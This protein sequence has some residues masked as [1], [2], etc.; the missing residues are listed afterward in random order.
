MANTAIDVTGI[1]EA[2]SSWPLEEVSKFK[3]E[4]NSAADGI[5]FVSILGQ[6]LAKDRL[7]PRQT[8]NRSNARPNRHRRKQLNAP[9]P[10]Y[11]DR[12]MEGARTASYS[13]TP[14]DRD[15]TD[16]PRLRHVF[17]RETCK[18]ACQSTGFRALVSR[19]L[20]VGPRPKS[21]I[22]TPRQE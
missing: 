15:Q 6:H 1:S 8:L 2:T 7:E 18:L 16:D 21:T 3:S 14:R 5:P 9:M 17:V 20:A 10:A 11:W 22:F 13:V 4:I 12:G 19:P